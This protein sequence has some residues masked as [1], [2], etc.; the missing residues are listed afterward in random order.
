M[1]NLILFIIESEFQLEMGKI[2][3]WYGDKVV[4]KPSK[5][6]EFCALGAKLVLFITGECSTNCFYCPISKERRLDV[7]FADEQ[8]ISNVE[9]AIHEA[10]QISALGVGITGG[11]PTLKLDRI[12]RYI[13][14]F[15]REFGEDFHCHL[16][17]SN[18]LSK[19]AL[20]KL[21]QA[22]LDE[23]RFHP[24]LLILGKNMKESIQNAKDLDWDV[25]IEIPVIP[26]NEETLE[27]II[28]FAS[29]V[30]LDFINLN[31]F[32]FTETNFHFLRERGFSVKDRSSAAVKGS[33]TF[34]LE[35]LKKFRKSAVPLHYCSSSYKDKVQLR[36]RFIRRA[37]NYAKPFDEITEE[38]LIVRARINVKNSQSIPSIV[39]ALKEDH[40]I[41]DQLI[42]VKKEDK[43]IS[44]HWKYAEKLGKS[45]SR[46]FTKDIVSIEI[47]HQYPYDGGFITYLNPIIHNKNQ[48]SEIG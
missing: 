11:E 3:K 1:F 29:K 24:P 2:T 9:E 34:A 12:I 14:S 44:T 16:Y 36:N 31:E 28:T 6:C 22:G 33:E 20:Q 25:G 38:G 39:Q 23:I 32:E 42:E 27:E 30:R 41:D 17:T 40:N 21:H 4:G 45:L 47:I 48:D 10:K 15:K 46:K 19:D 37:K 26:N 13:L 7:Q 35:T 43:T 5:G 8:L 18:A